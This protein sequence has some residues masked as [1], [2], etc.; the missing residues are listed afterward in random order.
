M[1]EISPRFVWVGAAVVGVMALI[2]VSTTIVVSYRDRV[3][4]LRRAEDR[5]ASLASRRI[6]RNAV[7]ERIRT[8]QSLIDQDVVTIHAATDDEAWEKARALV[9]PILEHGKAGGISLRRRLESGN[10]IPSSLAVEATFTAPRDGLAP[11]LLALETAT[12]RAEIG[13]IHLDATRAATTGLV[14]VEVVLRFHRT[15]IPTE[16]GKSS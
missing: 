7:D 10:E 4:D 9:R 14:Q 5:L 8:L 3:A 2:T 13:Q 6:D 1:S 16:G 12:P 15:L 11:L